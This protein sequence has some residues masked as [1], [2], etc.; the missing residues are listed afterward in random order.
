MRRWLGAVL[1]AAIVVWGAAPAMALN[2]HGGEFD[3]SFFLAAEFD[4]VE[5]DTVRNLH[6]AGLGFGEI[7]RLTIAAV[8]TGQSLDE[9]VETSVGDDG[10]LTDEFEAFL[11]NVDPVLLE[12]LPKNL[13]Q[14]IASAHRKGHGHDEPTGKPERP[15]TDR[16]ES[17]GKPGQ[18]GDADKP[19]PPD[20]GEKPDKGDRPDKDDKPDKD[21]ADHEHDED[22]DDVDKDEA[23]HEHD[24]DDSD[25]MTSDEFRERFAELEGRKAAAYEQYKVCVRQSEEQLHPA[26]EGVYAEIESLTRQKEQRL[27]ELYDSLKKAESDDT[28]EAVEEQ[29]RAVKAEYEEQVAALYEIKHDLIDAHEERVDG[30][31]TDKHAVWDEVDALIRELKAEFYG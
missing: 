22:G 5:V 6:D 19:A 11:R 8:V 31:Y 1:T 3:V 10:E 25:E 2:H 28:Y 20:T 9:V 27:G 12:G 26:K 15:E 7:F 17:Q 4:Q 24:D 29:I 14:I 18:S 23:D 13:G 30:C 16:P 21:E